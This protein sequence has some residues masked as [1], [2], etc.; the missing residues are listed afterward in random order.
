[1]QRLSRF[2]TRRGNGRSAIAAR[3]KQ[4]AALRQLRCSH[5]ELENE[6]KRPWNAAPAAHVWAPV[7]AWTCAHRCALLGASADARL[8]RLLPKRTAAAAAARHYGAPPRC[9][10]IG[11]L[12]LLL[13][14]LFSIHVQR[15]AC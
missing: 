12:H 11:Q 10:L 4:P 2:A 6:P 1:M 3:Y 8:P 14:L 15:C 9:F 7:G 13:A 5:C